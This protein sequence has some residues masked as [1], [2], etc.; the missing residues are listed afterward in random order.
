MWSG[1][2][3]HRSR[4][5]VLCADGTRDGRPPHACACSMLTG[6]G[7]IQRRRQAELVF[8]G[9]WRRQSGGSS[10]R[11]LQWQCGIAAFAL[12]FLKA[13]RSQPAAAKPRTESDRNPISRLPLG[14]NS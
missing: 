7:R 8:L 12:R 9:G 6:A 11:L 4:E 10:T 3:K 5:A 14:Y 1:V 2:K 13:L